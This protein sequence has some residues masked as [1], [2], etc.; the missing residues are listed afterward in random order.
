M[1]REDHEDYIRQT[2]QT[3]TYCYS[4]SLEYTYQKHTP[5]HSPILYSFYYPTHGGP[6][7]NL[8][9]KMKFLRRGERDQGE[10]E[11]PTKWP[12]QI[13]QLLGL[14]LVLRTK[15]PTTIHVR[16]FVILRV[17][18]FVLCNHRQ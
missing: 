4:F 7:S 2:Q 18:Q 6:S 15:Q 5:S 3:K 1:K 17:K 8:I 13:E 10:E 12:L 9:M 11:R 16:Q 14:F